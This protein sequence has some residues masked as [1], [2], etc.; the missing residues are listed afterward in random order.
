MAVAFGPD[1]GRISNKASLRLVE[2]CARCFN[3]P[4]FECPRISVEPR[5]SVSNQ[6][7]TL[8]AWN[9]EVTQAGHQ[10]ELLHQYITRG[11]ARQSQTAAC[12]GKAKGCQ[13]CV[14]LNHIH[15]PGKNVQPK[16]LRPVFAVVSDLDQRVELHIA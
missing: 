13:S 16:D 3:D 6:I 10:A 2:R 7:I 4:V 1:A 9:F 5:A 14:D 11:W 12:G 15:R 8:N